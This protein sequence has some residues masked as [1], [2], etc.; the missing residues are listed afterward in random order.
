MPLTGHASSL[1]I[2]EAR[3]GH[4]KTFAEIMAEAN[5][6]LVDSKMQNAMLAELQPYS[7]YEKMQADCNAASS[8]P[9]GPR[10]RAEEQL[11]ALEASVSRVNPSLYD[12]NAYKKALTACQEASSVG[13]DSSLLQQ[14]SELLTASLLLHACLMPTAQLHVDWWAYCMAHSTISEALQLHG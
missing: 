8:S 5:S 10:G 9:L 3:L 14:S 12:T 2:S 13:L 11:S 6:V 7:C 4:G 1:A